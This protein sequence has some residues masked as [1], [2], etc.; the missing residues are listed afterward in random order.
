MNT[1]ET[2]KAE[3]MA[4]SQEYMVPT[5]F[6][7][8]LERE[9]DEAIHG[10]CVNY[11]YTQEA[12]RGRDE[13]SKLCGQYKQERDEARIQEDMHFQNFLQMRRERDEAREDLDNMQDQRDLAMKLIK[14]LEQ[15]RDEARTEL[16]QLK[17]GEK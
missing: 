13:W 9:R 17:E 4:F 12:R 5:E 6:A 14:R 10:S 1:P 8:R 2:D 7:R 16:A 3:R 11:N 15:E